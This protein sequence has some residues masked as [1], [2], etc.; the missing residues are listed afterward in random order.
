VAERVN[1]TKSA[2]KHDG[3][4]SVVD[5]MVTEIRELYLE[6]GVP[7]V[8]G[9]SGGKDS[10][11]VAQLVWL[12]IA[13]LKPAQRTKPIYAISTDTLVENPIVSAWV[14]SSLGRMEDAARS[15]GL[16]IQPRPLTPSITNTFWVNLIGRGYPAPRN[17]FRWC[18]E[19]LK[20]DASN[21]F[22]RSV[23]QENGE[24]VLVLGTR[25]AESSKRLANM[26]RHEARRVRD[27]LSPNS[28]L[29]NCMV[30]T[31][32]EDWTN[33]DVWTF[34]MQVQNPW[35]HSNKDLLTMYRGASE[36]GD[37]PLVVDE[38]TPS[39]GNSRFGCWV[40]TLVDQDKSMAAMIQNDAEKEWMEPLLQ[41]RNELDFRSD[42]DRRRDRSNRDFRRING[43]LTY[44]VSAI[45]GPKLVHGPYTQQARADW[46]RKLLRTQRIVQEL[47]PSEVG[48]IEL[49]RHDEL[50]EIR[51]IWVA[52]KHEIEDLLPTIYEEELGEPYPGRALDDESVFDGESLS[53]LRS[54]CSGDLEYE[55][56]R[57]LLDVELRFRAMAKR[58]NLF[59]ELERVVETCFY[60]SEEDALER[61]AHLKGVRTEESDDEATGEI[62]T[63]GLTV[64]QLPLLD[65]H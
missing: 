8:I 34:L 57:N 47:A 10:T 35:G 36:D 15:A 48:R 20:I 39:C 61:A 51:R 19:R 45:D 58:K 37:C 40:C 46:L 62:V 9:Y 42:A 54:L 28:R 13:G 7:W 5:T 24:A 49:I 43:T 38:T 64:R 44:H 60:D 16:P 25:K 55:M 56:L 31:P 3:L 53:L 26:K 50:E 2:F 1:N 27:R 32:I 23:V 22:I 29:T 41:F 6:D 30:Y 65:N 21:R 4:R 18:T 52:D 59:G 14:R 63:V 17:K 12:A 11:A 33:D